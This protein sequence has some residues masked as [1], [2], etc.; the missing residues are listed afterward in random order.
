MFLV[1]HI[2]LQCYLENFQRKEPC[3]STLSLTCHFSPKLS[4]TD[5]LFNRLC[6]FSRGCC[7]LSHTY[8]EWR[9]GWR[10]SWLCQ[11][12]VVKV[13]VK[14]IYSSRSI[15]SFHAQ[16]RLEHASLTVSMFIM[17]IKSKKLQHLSAEMSKNQ[18]SKLETHPDAY[19]QEEK[20]PLIIRKTKSLTFLWKSRKAHWGCLCIYTPMC[21]WKMSRRKRKL[22]LLLHLLKTGKTILFSFRFV[23]WLLKLI[24]MQL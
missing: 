16:R 22:L 7:L 5:M 8:L 24:H 13:G 21:V 14:W 15:T 23:S 12:D 9:W 20:L 17:T 3:S 6:T 10:L 2:I 18:I 11:S 4:E 1:Y 19:V